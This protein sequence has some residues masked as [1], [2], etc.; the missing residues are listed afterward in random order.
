MA[1]GSADTTWRARS[2]IEALF[3]E[4]PEAPDWTHGYLDLLGEQPPEPTGLAQL[5]W[6]DRFASVGYDVTA[7][8]HPLSHEY[9]EAQRRLDLAPGKHVLDIGCGPGNVTPE[10]AAAVGES[11]LAVGVDVSEPMLERAVHGGTDQNLGY[12]RADATDLPFADD[13]FD[14]V[15]SSMALQLLADPIAALDEMT[16][17]L[18]PAGQLVLF[19]TCN[20]GGLIGGVAALVLTRPAGVRMFEP[21]TLPDALAERGFTD[22]RQ[23]VGAVIQLVRATHP[24]DSDVGG[25]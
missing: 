20:S 21:D 5:L 24:D 11:G 15:W 19:T 16:R 6:L 2:R 14:V 17:L 3:A 22:I 18:R 8:F 12:I 10:F 1:G 7:R 25:N 4:P 13:T 9:R 23:R